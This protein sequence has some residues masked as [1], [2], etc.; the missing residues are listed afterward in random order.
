MMLSPLEGLM[1]SRSANLL[2]LSQTMKSQHLMLIPI[3]QSGLVTTFPPLN[4]V[5]TF[6]ED[7]K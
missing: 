7:S 5:E 3:M 6:S 2:P 4:C 1:D